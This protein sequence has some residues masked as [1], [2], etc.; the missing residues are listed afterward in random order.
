[1]SFAFPPRFTACLAAVVLSIAVADSDALPGSQANV[2]SNAGTNC[3]WDCK[4][5]DS[6]FGL[7]MKVLISEFRLISLQLKHDQQV[8]EKC[9]NQ[10]DL[11]NSSLAELWIWLTGDIPS[12]GGQN[13]SQHSV[14]KSNYWFR[15]LQEGQ[16][17]VAVSC[18]LKPAT[19]S[20]DTKAYLND[21][22]A[23][24][25]LEEVAKFVKLS[26]SETAFCY[27]FSAKKGFYV[28][29]NIT[30]SSTAHKNPITWQKRAFDVLV[31]VVVFVSLCCFPLVSFVF[32]PTKKRENGKIMIV[33]HGT[34][35]ESIRS[36]IANEF[37]SDDVGD[38]PNKQNRQKYKKLFYAS[39]FFL[40]AVLFSFLKDMFLDSLL[41]PRNLQD[42]FD[43]L[44]PSL[45]LLVASLYLLSVRAVVRFRCRRLHPSQPCII[46]SVFGDKQEILHYLK[47]HEYYGR[48]E[49]EMHLLLL[50]SIVKRCFTQTFLKCNE[51][52]DRCCPS[53]LVF[54][55]LLFPV[56]IT[57]YLV[58]VVAVL[59]YSSPT[60][61]FYDMLMYQNPSRLNKRLLLSGFFETTLLLY[62]SFFVVVEIA[63]DSLTIFRG[64]LRGLPNYLPIASLV[65]VAVFYLW[66][67]YIPYPR[68]YN[69]LTFKLSE[70]YGKK[71]GDSKDF[72]R[73][74]P[75]DLYD[76]ACEKLMP[77][78]N[79]RGKVIAYFF[80]ILIVMF[81]VFV[82]VTEAPRAD[83]LTKA[84]GTLLAILLPQIVEMFFGK[85]PL[86]K[87]ADD[88]DFDKKVASFVNEYLSNNANQNAN[89]NNNNGSRVEITLSTDTTPLLTS[90]PYGSYS[91]DTGQG[92]TSTGA[93]LP[94]S[95]T[96]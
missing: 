63:N 25:L 87:K 91:E 7:E 22:I 36:R 73:M 43:S 15:K 32:I 47:N 17:E 70:H 4:V 64:C 65:A 18:S 3:A 20:T 28:C 78:K 2:A 9:V 66:K 77:L 68:Y 48:K 96:V 79:S 54:S 51:V 58:Y 90:R 13:M 29:V 38:D 62:G 75:K 55:F 12:H 6:T 30:V 76:E 34:S 57:V 37:F 39:C 67:V 24:V 92:R 74:I 83:D 72:I 82:V 31:M 59:L 81:A 19:D 88:E 60:S 11:H 35:P 33:L 52:L 45:Y 61:T 14:N 56:W 41:A 1:M 84:L 80:A 46:C 16:I 21:V 8:N 40:I 89:S 71:Q 27:K 94:T 23:M 5:V 53:S 10:T 86:V 42:E 26:H 49:M 44:H 69:K 95:E 50:P 85:D 93:L